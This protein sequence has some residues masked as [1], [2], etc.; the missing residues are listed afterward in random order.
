V[1][2]KFAF[3]THPDSGFV[4]TDCAEVIGD[5]HINATYP[6]GWGFGYGSYRYGEYYERDY[7][8]TNYPSINSKTIRHIVGVPNHARAWTSKFYHSIGGHNKNLHVADD[9]ELLVRTFLNTRMTHVKHFGYIQYHHGN[10]TQTVRNAEIQRLV[11][12]IWLA[13]EEDIHNRF[14][15]LGV[16]DFIWNDG[17]LMWEMENPENTPI[18]NYEVD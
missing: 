5:D 10:N 9:Y 11:K 6:D 13:Y 15:E 8:V 4:Y 3:D 16:D 2:I 18:A 1:S 14:I 12:L 7:M 17:M